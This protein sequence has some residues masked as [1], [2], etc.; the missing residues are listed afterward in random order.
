MKT[1]KKFKELGALPAKEESTFLAPVTQWSGSSI[2]TLL[3]F[4]IGFGV[5]IL[6]ELKDQYNDQIAWFEVPSNAPAKLRL[7]AQTRTRT[8]ANDSLNN[9]FLKLEPLGDQSK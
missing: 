2:S 4:L 9:D 5:V 6:T 1:V 7:P 8:P 3:G